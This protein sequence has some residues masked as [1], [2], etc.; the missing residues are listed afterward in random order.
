MR[1]TKQVLG[2]PVEHHSWRPRVSRME[3]RSYPVT[4]MWG[5]VNAIEQVACH[6]QEICEVC[7]ATREGAECACDLERGE[8]CK[9]LLDLIGPI[10][11][12]R[13]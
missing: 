13:A 7:G 9:L 5:R 8:R 3:R 2:V 4:D 1:C 6:K 11:E 10:P 12:A